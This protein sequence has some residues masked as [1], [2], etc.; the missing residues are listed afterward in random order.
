[1]QFV[2]ATRP[3]GERGQAAV[4]SWLSPT[5]QSKRST[6]ERL[7]AAYP[8]GHSQTVIAGVLGR[9][10]STISRELCR[11]RG[12]R[13]TGPSRPTSW[14]WGDVWARFGPASVTGKVTP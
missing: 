8:T 11:N 12:R 6:N 2:S 4:A 9:D 7:H 5:D 1:M 10:K 14:R 13:V 3:V